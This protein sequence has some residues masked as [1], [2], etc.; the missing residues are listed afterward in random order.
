MTI[1]LRL[2]RLPT[3]AS[4]TLEC[5]RFTSTT[6]PIVNLDIDPLGYRMIARYLHEQTLISTPS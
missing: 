6:L 5:L 4:G 3:Q 1:Q 2:W